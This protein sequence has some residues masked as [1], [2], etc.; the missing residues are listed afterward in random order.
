MCILKL[1]KISYISIKL[2]LMEII[3]HV[4]FVIEVIFDTIDNYYT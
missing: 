2:K 3:K 4:L 1:E